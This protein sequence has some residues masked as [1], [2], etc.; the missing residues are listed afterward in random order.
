MTTDHQNSSTARNL[1]GKQKA[2]ADHYLIHGDKSAAYRHAYATARSKPESVHRNA[3]HL[4]ETPHVREY[5]QAHQQEATSDAV[6]TRTQA[7]EL[8]TK[9]ANQEPDGNIITT[10]DRISAIDKLAK[11]QGWDTPAKVDLG[12][13]VYNITIPVC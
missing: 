9:I 4:F 13:I 7:L 10:R 12:N 2:A 3:C 8:L 5:V 6:L 1:T 11:L